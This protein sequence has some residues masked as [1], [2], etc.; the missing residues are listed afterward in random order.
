[1]ATLER[2]IEI[3]AKAHAGQTD[4]A[5]EAYIL[6]PLRVM[7]SLTTENERIAG[8]LHDVLED[9]NVTLEQLKLEGFANEVLVALVA[10]TKE[11][12]ESRMQAAA[13]AK[14]DPIARA[15]KLADNKDNSNISRIKSPTEKNFAR[16]EEYR[17]VRELLLS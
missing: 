12:G 6:H 4:K 7:L 15:V 5:G 16:L 11:K 3:A 2:A 13:R 8:V 17:A 14:K 10:L 9:T 1:M